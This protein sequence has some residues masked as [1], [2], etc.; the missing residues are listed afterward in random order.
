[1]LT[2]LLNTFRRILRWAPSLRANRIRDMEKDWIRRERTDCRTAGATTTRLCKDTKPDSESCN[3]VL[4][5]LIYLR[6][7]VA[8]LHGRR[9]YF[10]TADLH[11]V[12]C[13]QHDSAVP[14]AHLRDLRPQA[15]PEHQL[16]HRHVP[17]HW[18]PR[19][20][21]G[22]HL[23]DPG[24][25]LFSEYPLLTC[26]R[27]RKVLFSEQ[28]SRNR[29]RYI[30]MLLAISTSTRIISHIVEIPSYLSPCLPVANFRS[31]GNMATGSNP[32]AA[33]P[34]NSICQEF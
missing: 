28:R 17:F 14:G 8:G 29:E 9:H 16:L 15:H 18:R 22:S 23:V 25:Q 26:A 30:D 12:V 7:L 4:Q 1:M 3:M 13:L 6:R 19:H 24:G 20:L 31:Y 32:V 27:A 34:I 5:S 10:P 2:R 11:R 21:P 33:K